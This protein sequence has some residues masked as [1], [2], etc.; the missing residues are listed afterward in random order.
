MAAK[1]KE[2]LTKQEIEEK[3]YNPKDL[4][5]ERKAQLLNEEFMKFQAEMAEKLGMQ[6]GIRL[7]K[8]E[9]EISFGHQAILAPVKITP[10]KEAP[11]PEEVIK[12]IKDGQK[13]DDKEAT[14]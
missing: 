13:G 10:K 11:V 2:R 1:K 5:D 3:F 12:K 9:N 14:A 7:Q 6:V 8:I 4:S